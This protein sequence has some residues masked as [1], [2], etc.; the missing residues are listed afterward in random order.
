[1][2]FG[3]SYNLKTKYLKNTN[4]KKTALRSNQSVYPFDLN[5]SLAILLIGYCQ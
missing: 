3:I 5:L 4:L 1:M 2:K